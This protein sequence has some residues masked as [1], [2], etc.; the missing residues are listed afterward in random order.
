LLINV[1]AFR[2]QVDTRGAIGYLGGMP[3]LRLI[4][5]KPVRD[6]SND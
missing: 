2:T 4:T 5:G 3:S 1:E 6:P